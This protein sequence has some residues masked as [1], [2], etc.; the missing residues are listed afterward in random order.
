MENKK[1]NIRDQYGIKNYLT[2]ET[3]I[4]QKY[5]PPV[6]ITILQDNHECIDS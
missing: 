4:R 1:V 5:L 6:E 3:G 2:Q